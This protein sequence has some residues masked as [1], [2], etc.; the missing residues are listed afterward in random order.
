[1]RDGIQKRISHLRSWPHCHELTCRQSGA[2]RRRSEAA[3]NKSIGIENL[4]QREHFYNRRHDGLASIYN[5]TDM[6]MPAEGDDPSIIAAKSDA[7][8]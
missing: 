1:M 2:L 3:N 4:L 7:L 5:T 6:A 8:L